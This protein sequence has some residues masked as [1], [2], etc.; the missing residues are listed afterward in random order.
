MINLRYLCNISTKPFNEQCTGNIQN[1]LSI[2]QM[3][4]SSAA[5]ALVLPMFPNMM[6]F[7][8][9]ATFTFALIF[10]K[11]CAP[12]VTGCGFS[13]NFRSPDLKEAT[14]VGQKSDNSYWDA[15]QNTLNKSSWNLSKNIHSSLPKVANS[16]VRFCK[17]SEVWLTIST[18]RTMSY[19]LTCT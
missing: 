17:V 6:P 13:T 16:K 12:I 11:S 14:V 1:L 15:F 4:T 9:E 5:T 3:F 10:V 7:S 2:V 18:S 19:W 8:V